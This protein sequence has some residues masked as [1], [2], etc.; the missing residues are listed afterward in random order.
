[1]DRDVAKEDM[2]QLRILAAENCN[3]SADFAFRKLPGFILHLAKPKA[4][5]EMGGLLGYDLDFG[6][7][8]SVWVFTLLCDDDRFD[9]PQGGDLPIDVQHLRL[10][11]GRAVKSDDRFWLRQLV[12]CLESNSPQDES[13]RK[14][15]IEQPNQ[16][17]IVKSLIPFHF[18]VSGS[19]S[20]LS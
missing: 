12:Q 16:K 7:R 17:L 2:K 6:Q 15:D 5:Q 4:S 3:Q 13:V 10:K 20:T 8:K 19:I 18:P 1:M 11:K 14:A 9:P